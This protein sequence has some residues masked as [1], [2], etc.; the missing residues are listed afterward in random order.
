MCN[1][2]LQAYRLA[3][4]RAGILLRLFLFDWYPTASNMTRV[5]SVVLGLLL[6]KAFALPH[7][8]PIDRRQAS[9]RRD[10]ADRAQAVV[11]AFRTAWDGYHKFAFPHDELH[12]VS[13]T[14]SDSR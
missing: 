5:K 12:P 14:S 9:E 7:S 11:E 13:N 1:N 3:A 6:S 10:T 8:S 4:R 2:G